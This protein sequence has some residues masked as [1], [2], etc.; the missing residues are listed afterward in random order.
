M[1]FWDITVYEA[2]RDLISKNF[3]KSSSE[4]LI[5][6]QDLHVANNSLCIISINAMCRTGSAS[7]ICPKCPGHLAE[8]LPQVR[9]FCPGYRRFLS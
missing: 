4:I 5:L 6:E 7:S 8:V 2:L 1:R 9:H 3:A